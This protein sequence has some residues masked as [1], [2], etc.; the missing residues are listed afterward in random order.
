MSEQLAHSVESG[1]PQ[2]AEQHSDTELARAFLEQQI[3]A[4]CRLTG[5]SVNVALGKGWATNIE[6]G[7]LSIDPSF[8]TE[9]GYSP[10]DSVYASLHELLAHVRDVRRDPVYAARQRAFSSKD[11]AHHL[12]NNI[13]ADIHG[14]RSIHTLLPAQTQV[15]AHLYANKLFPVTDEETGEPVDYAAKPLHVQFLYKMIREMMIPG[16]ET[17]A[18]PEV[19]EALASLRDYNGTGYDMIDYL[20]AP[21]SKMKGTDRFDRQL[22]IIYPV[23]EKLLE[24]A[25]Q[26][27]SQN[28]SGN[29]KSGQGGD[30]EQDSPSNEGESSTTDTSEVSDVNDPFTGEYADYFENKHPEPLTPDEEEKLEEVIKQSIGEQQPPK[31]PDPSRAFNERIRQET[32]FDA[33]TYNAYTTE[34]ERY[35]DAIEQMRA[36]F[37]LVI[38][39]RVAE[40]RGLSRRAHVDGDLLD[41]NRL[42][43]AIIDMKSGVT[44]PEAFKR[45][46]KKER[47]TEAVGKTDYVFAFDRS[48][49]MRGA[50]AEAAATS[51]VIMLEALAGMERDIQKAEEQTGLNLELD[52]RTALYTFGETS[53]C[54]KPLGAG[55]DDQK[56]LRVRDAILRA[57]GN[58]TYDFLTLQ[59]IAALEQSENRR[60]LIVVSDGESHGK[61]AAQQALQQL[62]QQNWLVYGVAIGST[63]AEALY[64]PHSKLINDPKEL[65]GVLQSFIESTIT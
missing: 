32:G 64:A 58:C 60:I 3:P 41:P 26:E 65:P 43:Q 51:A 57:D 18:R 20:T 8:F 49:S 39:E 29:G 23:Y 34:V 63:A 10:E 5:L 21:N 62:H 14:N 9:R 44:Q 2:P 45:Y 30:L 31:K 54:I 38:N 40:K 15:G 4:L 33:A 22:A 13:L 59:E 12:F 37:Q 16:S 61:E 42:A 1:Q 36:V 50:S 52:I 24:Q 7:D 17:A 46:E 55:L 28:Q 19:D 25:K 35:R 47:N 27:A 11:E 53:E 48:S 6:T 56:R